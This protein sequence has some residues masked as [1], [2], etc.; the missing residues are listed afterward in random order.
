MIE[1][2]RGMFIGKAE[3]KD[4]CESGLWGEIPRRMHEK[5]NQRT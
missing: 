5:Y 2:K 4:N 1:I 3:K